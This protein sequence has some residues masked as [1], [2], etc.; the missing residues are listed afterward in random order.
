MK[1]CL[2][3]AA[4]SNSSCTNRID[5]DDAVK[6]RSCSSGRGGRLGVGLLV[7]AVLSA[8]DF[9][10]FNGAIKGNNVSVKLDLFVD[11]IGV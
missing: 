10:M 2:N 7:T 8:G 1:F 4:G 3:V 6:G 11:F 5:G 9:R